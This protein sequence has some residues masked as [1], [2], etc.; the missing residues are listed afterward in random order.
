M[1][2]QEIDKVTTPRETQPGPCEKLFGLVITNLLNVQLHDIKNCV[3]KIDNL[4][5]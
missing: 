3:R 5:L 4:K 2:G 1:C